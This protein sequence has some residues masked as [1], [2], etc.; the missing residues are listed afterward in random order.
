[1]L[2][3]LTR[4]TDIGDRVAKMN[5][6]NLHYEVNAIDRI[7]SYQDFQKKNKKFVP[8]W[9][10]KNMLSPIPESYSEDSLKG[11]LIKYFEGIS[12]KNIQDIVNNY[13]EDLTN[14]TI[15][16]KDILVDNIED[17]ELSEMVSSMSNSIHR[18][19]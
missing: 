8:G 1:M 4:K 15:F 3:K 12:D 17:Q 16:D 2:R 18:K 6:A 9:N 10:L 11:K 14:L 5:G 13:D 7:E 19:N